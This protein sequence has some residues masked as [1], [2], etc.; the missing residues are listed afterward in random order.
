MNSTIQDTEV[1]GTALKTISM[2]LRNTAGALQEMGEDSE[3][4]AES[5]TKLQQQLLELTNNKVDI[6]LDENTF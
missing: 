4:A 6:M 2:R 5:I 3:G 1:T